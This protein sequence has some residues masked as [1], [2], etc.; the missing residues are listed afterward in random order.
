MAKHELECLGGSLSHPLSYFFLGCG[1]VVFFPLMSGIGR[2]QGFMSVCKLLKLLPASTWLQ[3]INTGII[4][5]TYAYLTDPSYQPWIHVKPHAIHQSSQRGRLA[6]LRIVQLYQVCS[7]IFHVAIACDSN[8]TLAYGPATVVKTGQ[9]IIQAK[10]TGVDDEPGHWSDSWL[11]RK[12]LVLRP[13][14]TEPM[15]KETETETQTETD[16]RQTYSHTQTCPIVLMPHVH[17]R[18]T[19]NIHEYSTCLLLIECKTFSDPTYHKEYVW[20]CTTWCRLCLTNLLP[21]CWVCFVAID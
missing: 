4:L 8:L 2:R 1:H 5:G 3:Q 16:T 14:G 15:K 7:I 10:M 12:T 13:R 17:T 21:V 18:W 20:I 11:D 19:S 6:L 9:A